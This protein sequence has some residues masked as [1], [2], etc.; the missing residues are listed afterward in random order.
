MPWGVGSE[1]GVLTSGQDHLTPVS[2][3]SKALG[4]RLLLA[5][6]FFWAPPGLVGWLTSSVSWTAHLPA[7]HESFF[8]INIKRPP[9]THF[10]NADFS[11]AQILRHHHWILDLGLSHTHAPVH[12]YGWLGLCPQTATPPPIV[13]RYVNF[14]SQRQI[15]I[16]GLGNTVISRRT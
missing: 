6:Q 1:W 2:P 10:L 11:P 3:P 12:M 15:L 9:G 8:L 14:N 4:Q 13:C 7:N 5:G 16:P